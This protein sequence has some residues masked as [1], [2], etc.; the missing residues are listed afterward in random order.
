[1]LWLF[2]PSWCQNERIFMNENTSK[3]QKDTFPILSTF[4]EV[5][6]K[7]QRSKVITPRLRIMQLNIMRTMQVES[8][9][10]QRI[11]HC[12]SMSIAVCSRVHTVQQ[13]LWKHFFWCSNF[14]VAKVLPCKK[15]CFSVERRNSDY[16]TVKQWKKPT[17]KDQAKQGGSKQQKTTDD[18]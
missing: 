18:T 14:S 11:Q 2:H 5:D 6:M 7:L 12:P 3:F 4:A 10:H 17:D 13:K 16:P 1:M 9:N 8:N 15:C